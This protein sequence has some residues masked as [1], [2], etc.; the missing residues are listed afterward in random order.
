MSLKS[1]LEEGKEVVENVFEDIIDFFTQGSTGQSGVLHSTLGETDKTVQPQ[2]EDL[3]DEGRPTDKELKEIDV[4][5]QEK[6]IEDATEIVAPKSSKS[7]ETI[8]AILEVLR[9][10]VKGT[11]VLDDTYS[12]I[13]DPFIIGENNTLWTGAETNPNQFTTISSV[14]ELETEFLTIER[15]I[16]ELIVHWT[17]SYQNANLNAGQ[18]HDRHNQLGHDGIVYHYIIRRDGTLQRGRPVEKRSEAVENHN[19][20]SIHIAF[21]GGYNT[22]TQAKNFENNTGIRSLNRSQFNTF[23][24]LLRIF[25][26]KYPGG[27]VLGHND[28]DENVEDPGFD[29]IEY[30]YNKFGKCVKY[31]DTFDQIELTPTE[32]NDY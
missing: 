1:I 29:V 5:L 25:Y 8:Q 2:V 3:F 24:E 31:N 15:P 27:Q 16:T 11:I 9:P 26:A 7:K 13:D 22:D 23:D 12:A 6:R 10:T 4:A 20:Y 28:L 19:A 30:V 32:L 17:E 21:V 14:E 18:L